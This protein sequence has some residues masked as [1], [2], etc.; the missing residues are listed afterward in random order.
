VIQAKASEPRPAK[1]RKR[2][3]NL[4]EQN[5]ESLIH[6]AALGL[7]RCAERFRILARLS[8][9]HK[10]HRWS[11]MAHSVES[12]ATNLHEELRQMPVKGGVQ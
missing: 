12:A 10:S 2:G 11:N 7:E 3:P 8:H 9:G 6:W 4:A 1:S 5:P